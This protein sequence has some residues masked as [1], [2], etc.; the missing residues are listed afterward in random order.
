MFDRTLGDRRPAGSDTRFVSAT[1]PRVVGIE[2]LGEGAV[3]VLAVAV[4]DSG[5]EGGREA[6]VLGDVRADEI[7]ERAGRENRVELIVRIFVPE[8]VVRRRWPPSAT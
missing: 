2:P 7:G 4:G 6:L 1:D 3:V 5:V 8:R